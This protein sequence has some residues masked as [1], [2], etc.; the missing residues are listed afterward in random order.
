[1][2]INTCE[3]CHYFEDTAH[4]FCARWRFYTQ[5]TGT[6]NY[7]ERWTSGRL[8]SLE[9]MKNKKIKVGYRDEDNSRTD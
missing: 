3:H 8:D 5:K 6:C 7:F 9:E 4:P 2:N 1:M